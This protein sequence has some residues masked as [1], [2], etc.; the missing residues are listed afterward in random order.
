LNPVLRQGFEVNEKT[1]MIRK[2]C[3]GRAK[4][5]KVLRRVDPQNAE[6]IIKILAEDDAGRHTDARHA[7][8]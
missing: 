8:V 5:D 1:G 3:R 2:A 6:R 4:I 7:H